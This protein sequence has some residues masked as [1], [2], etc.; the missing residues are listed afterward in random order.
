MSSPVPL[1]VPSDDGERPLPSP[2]ALRDELPADA[3]IAA[4]VGAARDAIRDL[5]HGRDPRR[6]LVVVGPCSI[7]DPVAALEYARL[8]QKAARATS[9]Q[10]VV[11]MRTYFEK[12][13]TSVGWKGWIYDPHLDGSGDVESGLRS[14]RALLLEING[15]G[16]PCGG[17][18]LDPISSHYLADLLSWG[19]IGARTAESQ[20]HRELASALPLP[21]GVKNP[22]SGDLDVAVHAMTAIARPQH[23]LSLS[24][25]GEAAARRSSG[26]P[27]RSLVLRGSVRAPNCHALDVA[28]A[29]EAT[30][31][32]QLA[33]PLIV[34]CSHDN[35]RQ[36]HRRQPAVARSV[37]QQIRGGQRAIMGLLLE[38]HLRPGRQDLGATGP[39][40]LEY[41]VSVTDG[42]IGWSETERLL[43]EAA[44]VVEGMRSGGA[45]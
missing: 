17:E 8:L 21:I 29:L 45:T 10:L 18:I 24:A 33:R 44:E 41:G 3:R 31:G 39:L 32:Q 6:L 5:L 15:M 28:R 12:P 4:H 1:A 14:A 35:S 30:R 23:M 13:R 7:H 20:T 19:A 38:S 36:D 43:F 27:D 9:D 2:A 11:V 42:C 22:T 37:L 26:N 40:E 25:T 34:D 16:L